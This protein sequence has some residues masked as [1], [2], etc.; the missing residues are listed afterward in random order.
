MISIY[1][2]GEFNRQSSHERDKNIYLFHADCTDK[3]QMVQ[4]VWQLDFSSLVLF[5]A[6]F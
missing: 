1:S 4:L 6:T 5:C 2:L 3:Y